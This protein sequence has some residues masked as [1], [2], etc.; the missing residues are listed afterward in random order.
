MEGGLGRGRSHQQ[1]WGP[2]AEAHHFLSHLRQSNNTGWARPRHGAPVFAIIT[3]SVKLLFSDF[4]FLG[5]FFK[6]KL[7]SPLLYDQKTSQI[8]LSFLF[9]YTEVLR[10]S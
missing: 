8:V 10:M 2:G 3:F 5:F 6:V 7:N 9:S 1:L 4:L